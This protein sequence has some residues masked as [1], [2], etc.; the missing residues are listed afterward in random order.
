MSA[1]SHEEDSISQNS[2][3]LPVLTFFP[4]PLPQCP[5]SFEGFDINVLLT[6]ECSVVIYSE[7][8]VPSLTAA[9]YRDASLAKVES[10]INL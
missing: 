9:D 3:H 7:L 10:S 8:Q 2:V 4:P 6:A 1:L 5:L